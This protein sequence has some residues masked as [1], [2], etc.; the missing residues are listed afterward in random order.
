MADRNPR[1]RRSDTN[2]SR[3]E[4][5]ICSHAELA[6][7]QLHCKKFAAGNST[8]GVWL[9]FRVTV[10][11]GLTK[12]VSRVTTLKVLYAFQCAVGVLNNHCI[13]WRLKLL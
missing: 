5:L 12:S 6:P 2:I 7:D 10:S 13:V 1:V 11:G 4:E 8:D 9:G 3:V